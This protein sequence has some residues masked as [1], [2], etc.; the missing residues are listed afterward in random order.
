MTN[1]TTIHTAEGDALPGRYTRHDDVYASGVTAGDVIVN[2]FLGGLFRVTDTM[3]DER[4][5]LLAGSYVND[6]PATD[7]PHAIFVM[8]G[9]TVTHFMRVRPTV[10][11]NWSGRR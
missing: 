7:N 5:T 9:E 1:T 11:Y 2:P 10:K 8:F 4:G 3:T 6:A